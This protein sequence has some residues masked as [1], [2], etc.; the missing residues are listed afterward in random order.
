MPARFA[1]LIIAAAIVI[2]V[3]ALAAPAIPAADNKSGA[4]VVDGWEVVGNKVLVKVTNFG[5]TRSTAAVNVQ[6][7][8]TGLPQRNSASV[9]VPPGASEWAVVGFIGEVKGV[10]VVGIGEG[11]EPIL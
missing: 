11:A 7:V 3:A 4:L 9:S 2:L 1:R 6:A 10:I 5:S 8:A